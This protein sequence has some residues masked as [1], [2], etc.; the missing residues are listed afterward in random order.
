MTKRPNRISKVWEN[1][2]ARRAIKSSII[3]VPA[4]LFIVLQTPIQLKTSIEGKAG[5]ELIIG[6]ELVDTIEV[7]TRKVIDLETLPAFPGAE[8]YGAN[9]TWGLKPTPKV[10][11]ASIFGFPLSVKF[12]GKRTGILGS[13]VPNDSVCN[14]S[15]TAVHFVTS[16]SSAG[17]G[18]LRD[19]ID[20]DLKTDTLDII[21]FRTGGN[22]SVA[23]PTIFL[24][25]NCVYIAGQTAPGGGIQVT[26]DAG[27]P[28]LI[29]SDFSTEA[30]IRYVRFR[31]EKGTP[32]LDDVTGMRGGTDA[33]WDHV[34]VEFGNNENFSITS[35]SG[36]TALQRV[37]VQRSLIAAG[38]MSN[39]RG[40]S[41][42]GLHDGS[43]AVDSVTF[44][45]NLW[46]HNEQHSPLIQQQTNSVQLINNVVY[47]WSDWGPGHDSI[48]EVDHV[49]N[50]YKAGPWS[51]TPLMVF[52][53]GVICT[54]LPSIFFEANVYAGVIDSTASQTPLIEYEV[55]CSP[56]TAGDTLASGAF[57][58]SRSAS[59]AIA[60]TEL[61]AAA[62]F[63][64][65][66]TDVG[67]NA[68]LACNGLLTP[69]IDAL[70]QRIIDEVNA[71]TGPSVDEEMDDPGDLG[72]IPALA[73]GTA[74]TDADSDG[75]ADTWESANSLNPADGTDYTSDADGD[76]YIA[77]EEYLNNT[78]PNVVGAT[79]PTTPT[80]LAWTLPSTGAV[81]DTLPA[82]YGAEGFGAIAWSKKGP[83]DCRSLPIQ[84]LTV[85]NLNATGSGSFGQAMR[86]DSH[87]D[88][89]TFIIFTLGGLV[90]N[91][92]S[93]EYTI[94]GNMDCLQVLGQTAR[95][96]GILLADTTVD[97][98]ATVIRISERDTL[99][100]NHGPLTDVI[101][102]Y[103]RLRS[104]TVTGTSDTGSPMSMRNC[105]SCI[106]DHNSQEYG[107]QG[108]GCGMSVNLASQASG[109]R[110]IKD[111]TFSNTI[112]GAALSEGA[113]VRSVGNILVEGI[114]YHHNLWAFFVN[115]A[116]NWQRFD[117]LGISE[118]APGYIRLKR[119]KINDYQYGHVSRDGRIW[120]GTDIDFIGNR[121]DCAPSSSCGV[122]NTLRWQRVEP[123]GTEPNISSL[124]MTDNTH[125]DRAETNH[126]LVR[127]FDEFDTHVGP[128]PDSIKRD[129]IM[130][131]GPLFPI[132]TYASTAILDSLIGTSGLQ[133]GTV[134]VNRL[135]DCD[136][137]WLTAK[138]DTLD[139]WVI[140]RLRNN[141]SAPSKSVTSYVDWPVQDIDLPVGTACA[142]GDGG[143]LPDAWE[144][145]LTGGVSTTSATPE[146][147]CGGNG[148]WNIED[149][150]H[151]GRE[152]IGTLDWTDNASD[153][154]NYRIYRDIG[155][156]M[157]LFDTVSAGS[158]TYS[159]PGGDWAPAYNWEIR[160]VKAAGESDPTTAV[161]TTCP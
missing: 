146:G 38:L 9:A 138:R 109:G 134:G 47:N 8:G 142:D 68:N 18:T 49:R 37:T 60:V 157:I 127:E 79:V 108:V 86:F 1:N 30:I 35:A 130:N 125:A 115:R 14:R 2:I 24:D 129:T 147:D 39:S 48:P 22:I 83:A 40:G 118:L 126:D 6:H 21:I 148:Y 53:P 84:V 55:N 111:V 104:D 133:S 119:Q 17:A 12:V 13:V 99:N 128:L 26:K 36:G 7:S 64:D 124:Y 105:R 15:N 3:L 98:D 16:T 76:G 58:G 112:C 158:A 54:V 92:S 44:H 70:D 57:A 42:A 140:N 77:L 27:T 75:M 45:H 5:L 151:G 78:D 51:G 19:I 59:P 139:T 145:W 32:G 61:N 153:E 28:F 33:I 114:S 81:G 141:L 100:V 66:M 132:T 97:N 29:D 137:Q 131:P 20:N 89:A 94:D 31:S 34:S 11:Q 23:A 144:S 161:A 110:G 95:G 56:H 152:Q 87:A 122:A 65:V 116:P 106:I 143:G 52:N 74:C 25:T 50:Y 10:M 121:F 103:V 72:G 120:G 150:A 67:A 149:W 160:A 159:V 123:R 69:N 82:F 41:V 4:T 63:I 91:T 117:T 156:G 93:N 101:I 96:D 73:S 154:L 136:G 102:Q 62:A 71:G 155:D 43:N 80:G 46:A 107:N 90:S 113:L 135:M 88:S 85:T